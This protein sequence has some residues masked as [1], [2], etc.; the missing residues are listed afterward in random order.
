MKYNLFNSIIS[1]SI[2]KRIEQI[3]VFIE[4]PI[5]TQSNTLKQ[6][7]LKAKNTHWGK[8]Y[9][10]NEILTY[11]D[12]KKNVPIQSYE[13]IVPYIQ[14]IKKGEKNI[15]WPGNISFFAK[16]SGT[17][18]DKSKFIPITKESLKKSHLKAGKD[19]LS[20]Y[21][22]LFPN[23]LIFKGKSLMIGGSKSL[24]KEGNYTE[25][26]LSSILISNLPIWTT[27]LRTP[28]VNTALISDWEEKTSIAA[29]LA[30][31]AAF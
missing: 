16:S 4:K 23:S 15:L 28:N 29:L 9:Y 24:G 10:Y 11:N 12:F 2:K 6:L 5:E 31:L 8:K 26:D 13:N 7:I 17:T 19:M 30:T 27:F 3:N 21:M 14:M 25:G 22:N 20:T 1:W 18:D